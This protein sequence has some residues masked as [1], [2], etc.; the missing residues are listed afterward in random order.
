MEH[1]GEVH[2]IDWNPTHRKTFV[3]GSWD[4]TVR[5]WDRK[6]HKVGI[7]YCFEILISF[8]RMKMRF[9]FFDFFI[10]KFRSTIKSHLVRYV[11]NVN[12]TLSDICHGPLTQYRFDTDVQRTQILCL[13]HSVVAIPREQ[14][15]FGFGRPNCQNMGHQK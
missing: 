8:Q 14:V 7:F 11:K 13:Q 12:L 10:A 15:R 2:S 3:T 1:G 5:L 9:I 4:E 6:C